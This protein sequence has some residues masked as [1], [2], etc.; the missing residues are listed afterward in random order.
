MSEEL[1]IFIDGEYYLSSNAKISV[2]DHG[3][4]YGD[5]VFEGIREYDGKVFKLTEHIN[6][7]YDSAKML[8]LTIPIDKSEMI[9]CVLNTLKINNLSEAYIRLVVTRGFG[10]LGLDPLNCPKPTIIIIAKPMAPIA[11]PKGIK[12]I[13]CP[14][15]R[16]PPQV[17]S[18]N[19]KTL[20]YINN[21][22]AKMFA[23]QNGCAEAIFLD[24]NG[25]VAEGSAENIFM[26][27]NGLITTPPY[28]HSLRGITR[29]SLIDIIKT[30][31]IAEFE[32]RDASIFEY[33][34]ADEVFMTGTAAE[35]APVTQ[36]DGRI[37]GDGKPG[38][39][40]LELQWM[41]KEYVKDH[42]INIWR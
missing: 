9:E 19:A 7:L 29:D 23:T 16:I 3:I 33:Y 5:G 28:I 15:R 34:V 32:V 21:V 37:I 22:L 12:V 24:L 20:N 39:I 2:Y 40:T 8:N 38:A 35:L 17:F 41:F 13:T 1:K 27:K 25:N 42:G 18:P 30:Y 14:L 10:D 26:I 4:L 31:D 11:D 36:I 6:R